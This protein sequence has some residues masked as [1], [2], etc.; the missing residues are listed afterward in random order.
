MKNYK[1]LLFLIC[2]SL[3][4]SEAIKAATYRFYQGGFENGGY[5]T[6]SFSGEDLNGDGK[7]KYA[8]NEFVKYI[9]KNGFL[10]TIKFWFK[11]NAEFEQLNFA[12]LSSH[13]HCCPSLKGTVYDIAANQF[14]FRWSDELRTT[15]MGYMQYL[16]DEKEIK[17]VADIPGSTDQFNKVWTTK[18]EMK[19]DVVPLPGALVLFVSTLAGL[20]LVKR[21]QQV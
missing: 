13:D 14:V 4:F 15:P 18:D 21:R 20:A 2:F 12:Y 8:D 5:V 9:D 17:F 10:K 6:G 16:S 3:I 1:V 7:L 19:T 11:G